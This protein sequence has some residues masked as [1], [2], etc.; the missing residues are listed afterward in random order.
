MSA[1]SYL[2]TVDGNEEIQAA[3][4]KLFYL[5]PD[6]VHAIEKDAARI[7][8]LEADKKRLVEALRGLCWVV[9][10]GDFD[11]LSI[12]SMRANEARDL[13]SEVS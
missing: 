10:N 1:E 6:F 4:K 12:G 13:L 7:A 11:D 8:A 9:D 3:K 5:A 2:K